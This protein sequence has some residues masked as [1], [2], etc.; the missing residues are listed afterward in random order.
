MT[1]GLLPWVK[2]D[3]VIILDEQMRQVSNQVR[4][5]LD[6]VSLY[7][8]YMTFLVMD[9]VFQEKLN[10]V[11]KIPWKVPRGGQQANRFK[12]FSF[13][14]ISCGLS[15]T[16]TANRKPSNGISRISKFG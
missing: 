13:G 8:Q 3:N 14:Q 2:F 1:H 5:N 16:C 12:K 11:T 15:R 10:Q 4:D 7:L 6:L 9:H